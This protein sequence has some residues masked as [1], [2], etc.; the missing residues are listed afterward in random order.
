MCAY[1]ARYSLFEPRLATLMPAT[2]GAS[3]GATFVLGDAAVDFAAVDDDDIAAETIVA[4]VAAWP[5]ATNEMP[6]E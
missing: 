1:C 5:T 2:K 6:A 4:R 3:P